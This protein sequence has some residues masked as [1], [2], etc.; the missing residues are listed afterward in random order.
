MWHLDPGWRASDLAECWLHWIS[1]PWKRVTRVLT[2][3][4]FYGL[5]FLHLMF[6]PKPPPLDLQN[7]LPTIKVF[8]TVLLTRNSRCSQRN[9][10]VGPQSWDLLLLP[11]FPPLWSSWPDRVME[12]PSENTVPVPIRWQQHRGQGQSSSEG[13][14]CFEQSLI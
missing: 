14:I 11:Y 3:L 4:G 7:A 10:T 2:G 6:L 12:W 13:R 9:E 5:P 1:I 8:H